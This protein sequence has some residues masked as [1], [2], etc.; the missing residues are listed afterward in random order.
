MQSD[1]V[2]RTH[3]VTTTTD[4][5]CFC[6]CFSSLQADKAEGFINLCGF[7]IEQAKQC[8]KKQYAIFVSLCLRALKAGLGGNHQ[9]CYSTV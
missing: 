9:Q 6:L 2:R 7:T 4:A 5:Q 3:P 8:R 1:V